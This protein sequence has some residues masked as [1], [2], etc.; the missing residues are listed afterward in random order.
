LFEDP[1]GPIDCH[2]P[3]RDVVLGDY[4]ATDRYM[5]TL[6]ANF[7]HEPLL[8]G[9][10]TKKQLAKFDEDPRLGIVYA[11]GTVTLYRAMECD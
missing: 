1:I 7:L 3:G 2:P 10:L 4:I 8:V 11:D 9:P 5:L 6:R